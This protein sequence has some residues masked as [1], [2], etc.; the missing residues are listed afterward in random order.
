MAASPHKPAGTARVIV[1]GIGESAVQRHHDLHTSQAQLHTTP[2]ITSAG[3][4]PQTVMHGT[5]TTIIR[6][7]KKE[8]LINDVGAAIQQVGRY[9]TIYYYIIILLLLFFYY[10]YYYYYYIE[11]AV[12]NGSERKQSTSPKTPTPHN[13][14]MEGRKGEI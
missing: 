12:Q 9:T 1:S 11:S 13:Q 4:S 6:D 3:P 5:I 14:P 2:S 10:Y 7:G 8:T